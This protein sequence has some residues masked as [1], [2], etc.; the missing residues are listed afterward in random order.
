MRIEAE[1]DAR[2]ML[3]VALPPELRGRRVRVEVQAIDDLRPSQWETLS[4]ALDALESLALP[5]R[6]HAEILASLRELRDGSGRDCTN[7]GRY[8]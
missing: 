2:G 1:V 3:R 7:S 4:R 5:R 6:T 8:L